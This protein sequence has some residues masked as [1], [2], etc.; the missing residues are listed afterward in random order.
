MVGEHCGFSFCFLY[1]RLGA[2]PDG[3]S[4]QQGNINR[5]REK[6]ANKGHLSVAKE[7]GKSQS[8]KTEAWKITS[9][10]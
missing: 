2:V 3:R 7:L 4:Q 8:S 1:P 9:L 5:H 6:S 10:P